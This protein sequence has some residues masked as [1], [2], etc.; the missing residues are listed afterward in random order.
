MAS[1]PVIDLNEAGVRKLL[2]SEVV[3]REMVRRAQR[4]AEAAGGAPDFKVL[5]GTSDRA[6]AVAITATREGRRAEAEHRAL[7]RAIDAGR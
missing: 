5:T 3:R 4:I 1:I 6:I 2:N 7:T